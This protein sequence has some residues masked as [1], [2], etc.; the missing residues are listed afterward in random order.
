MQ[1]EMARATIGSETD[2]HELEVER[3]QMVIY[4]EEER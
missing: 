1:G 4:F 3:S 2:R